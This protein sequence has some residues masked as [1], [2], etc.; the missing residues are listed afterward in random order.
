MV[1]KDAFVLESLHVFII[2]HNWYD[3]FLTI[4]YVSFHCFDERKKAENKMQL[5]LKGQ[6]PSPHPLLKEPKSF[7]WRASNDVKSSLLRIT[8]DESG[9]PAPKTFVGVLLATGPTW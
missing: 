2:S 7:T 8:A 3:C 1:E 5:L 9:I 6:T 4:V